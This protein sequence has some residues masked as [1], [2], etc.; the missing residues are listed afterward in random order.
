MFK[1]TGHEDTVHLPVKQQLDQLSRGPGLYLDINVR[2]RCVVRRQ[3][4][5]K[6]QR[7]RGLHG[8]YTQPPT[9]LLLAFEQR[10]RFVVGCQHALGVL[11]QRR[12]GTRRANASCT[13]NQLYA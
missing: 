10:Y 11:H 7:R 8:A 4:R 12:S 9:R 6:A 3:Y 1:P 2:L 13:V 5:R